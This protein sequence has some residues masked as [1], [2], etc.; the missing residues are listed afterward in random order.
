MESKPKGAEQTYDGILSENASLK[1][2]IECLNEQMTAAQNSY[3]NES[4]KKEELQKKHSE[5]QEQY[6]EKSLAASECDYLKR[7]FK[8]TEADGHDSC[9]PMRRKSESQDTKINHF[10]ECQKLKKIDHHLTEQLQKAREEK[11]TLL[12]ITNEKSNKIETLEKE[13]TEYENELENLKKLLKKNDHH[14][15]EQLH[16]AKDEKPALLNM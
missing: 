10:E 14:L 2:V 6:K 16:K 11:Q 3:R 4:K 7:K 8:L 13:K 1:T 5:L 15:K 9:A 12:N